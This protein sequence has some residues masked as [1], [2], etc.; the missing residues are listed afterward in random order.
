MSE[1]RA[2]ADRLILI[3]T[4]IDVPY[5][6]DEHPA[7]VGLATESGDFDA[8]RARAGGLDAAFMSIY[9][10]ADLQEAGGAKE[11]ADELID[12]VEGIVNDH[13]DKFVIAS[14][15]QQ[16]RDA[17][18]AGLIALPLGIENGAPIEGELANLKHFFDRG[19]RY[20]TLT[21]SKANHICDSSY[22]DNRKWEGLSPFGHE[23]V[24]E[25]NRLGVM[26]DISH[27]SDDA[28]RQVAAVTRAPMLASHSSCRK[29]TP[30]FERNMD[31]DMIRTLAEGGGVIMINFGSYFLKQEWID[32]AKERNAAMEA[33]GIKPYDPVDREAAKAFTA[34]WVTERPA[35]FATLADVADHID[36]V[37]GL[38]GIDHVG[39]GSDFD[40]VGDSLPEGL[41]DVSGYPALLAELQSRGYSEEDLAKVAGENLLRVWEA[42]EEVAREL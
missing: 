32:W 18:A 6:L 38:V 1:E 22:D 28:F 5:R 39:L 10:P 20:I 34:R 12:L 8:P 14:T 27:V 23:L 3:D 24:A 11:K 7:D 29:F 19:V 9:V 30:G 37:V 2:L 13:P 15:P 26:V 36:H 25:M 31:D 21:H 16:V 33:E 35:P 42:V 4:H 40:G 17:A 41:K